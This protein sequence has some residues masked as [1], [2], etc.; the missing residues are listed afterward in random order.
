MPMKV[1][2]VLVGLLGLVMIIFTVMTWLELRKAASS[3]LPPTAVSM[4]LTKF[5]YPELFR[6]VNVG[7]K[8]VDPA[9][10][11]QAASNRIYIIGGGSFILVVAGLVMLVLPQNARAG[12]TGS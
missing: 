3:E 12:Q 9:E 2:G 7:G 5:V 6:P 8:A 1:T 11:A 4:P 10:L